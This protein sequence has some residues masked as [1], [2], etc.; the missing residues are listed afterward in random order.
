MI[1]TSMA[2]ST[3]KVVDTA[4]IAVTVYTNQALVTRRGIIELTGEERQLII[5]HLPIT[6]DSNSVR[7]GGNGKVGVRLLAVNTERVHLNEPS[8]IRTAQ[9]TQH[10]EQL[11][12]EMSYLS[13]QLDG[14]ALQARFIEGLREKTEEPFAQ[15]ISRKNLSLSETL[16]FINFLG[17]QY[18]EYG[19]A[20]RD[21]RNRK[22]EI[23]QELE[24]LRQQLKQIQTPAPRES[25]K[26]V[27]DIETTGAGEFELEVTY[28]VDCAAWI[29]VYDLRVSSANKKLN[30]SYIAEVTQNTGE[31]W[32][33]VTLTLSTAKPGGTLPPKLEPWY[34][35]ILEPLVASSAMSIQPA[36]SQVRGR[37]YDLESDKNYSKS[38]EENYVEAEIVTAEVLTTGSVVSFNLC[39]SVNI[40]SDK[41]P[42]QRTIL[43]SDLPCNFSHIAVPRLVNFAYLQAIVQNPINGATLLPGKAH[44]FRDN[45]FVGTTQLENIT[46]GQVFKINLGIDESLKIERDLVERQVDKKLIG[47]NRKVIYAYRLIVTNLLN[48]ETNLKLSEQVPKSK[49]EQIKVHLNRTNPQINEGEMGILEWELSMAPQSK[50]EIYYQFS[51]EHPP[52]LNI[53]GLD[54]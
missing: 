31:D 39:S 54:I 21:Y 27:V 7:A 32:D 13:A 28:F 14:L 48:Q 9:L 15:S 33:N 44:I 17:S 18:T 4:I 23:E 49:H 40:P 11:E 37:L 1:N 12:S 51:I 41:V 29:P 52:Q 3:I 35:D 26:L 46:P 47:G 36:L 34:I 22:Q 45:M 38:L 6:L 10:I 53:V 50:Q 16:D 25:F 42:H 8:S 20:T 24:P 19:I 43:N 5:N 2:P 30:L